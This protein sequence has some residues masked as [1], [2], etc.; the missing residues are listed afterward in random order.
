MAGLTAS[1]PLGVCIWSTW[2]ILAMFSGLAR[3]IHDVV[4]GDLFQLKLS[5]ARRSVEAMSASVDSL[6]GEQRG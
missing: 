5:P 3:E 6:L 1:G 4:V 2:W